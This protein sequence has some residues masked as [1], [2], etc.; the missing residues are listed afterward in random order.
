MDDSDFRLLCHYILNYSLIC[1]YYYLLY[2]GLICLCNVEVKMDRDVVMDPHRG[3][4]ARW[5][6]R[7]IHAGKIKLMVLFM[8]NP[9][10][11]YHQ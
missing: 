4:G 11:W 6:F 10:P 2:Y 7:E 9:S 1:Y 5:Y 3:H 8:F